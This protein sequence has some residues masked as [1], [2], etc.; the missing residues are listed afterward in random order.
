MLCGDEEEH[1]V[2]LWCWLTG[3]DIKCYLLLGNGLPEGPRAAYV[4]A[5][6]QTLVLFNASDGSVYD[7]SD[8]LCPL[9]S[10]GCAVNNENVIPQSIT[11]CCYLVQ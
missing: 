3:L 9:I 8:S 7:A 4:L 2:M 5:H 6:V 1:A 10:V 11:I